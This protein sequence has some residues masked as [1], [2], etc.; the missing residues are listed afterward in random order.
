M[1]QCVSKQFFVV[2]TQNCFPGFVSPFCELLVVPRH[3]ADRGVIGVLNGQVGSSRH[4][5]VPIIRRSNRLAPYLFDVQSSPPFAMMAL[6]GPVFHDP[7][8]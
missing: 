8:T 1:V 5:S 2:G 3:G 7:E 6:R 4:I